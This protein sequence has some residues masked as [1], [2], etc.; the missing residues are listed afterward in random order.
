LNSAAQPQKDIQFHHFSEE[1]GLPK[2]SVS[3]IIQDKKGYIWFGTE[4]Y[5][6]ASLKLSG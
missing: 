2:S 5:D 4:R 6:G 3:T 1:H